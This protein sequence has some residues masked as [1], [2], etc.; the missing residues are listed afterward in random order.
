MQFHS[1]SSLACS[2][3][4]AATEAASLPAQQPYL[5]AASPPH[6]TNSP[7]Q[8]SF[9]FPSVFFVCRFLL[10]T[11][12]FWKCTCA[13][14]FVLFAP[15]MERFC[16]VFRMLSA[17]T[18]YYP[19]QEG[20]QQKTNLP[21]GNHAAPTHS[22]IHPSSCPFCPSFLVSFFCLSS[23]HQAYL[24]LLDHLHSHPH[25]FS[26][27]ALIEFFDHGQ[28]TQR[29]GTAARG[30]A[31]KAAEPAW[32]QGHGIKRQ[33]TAYKGRHEEEVKQRIAVSSGETARRC[34]PFCNKEKR[35]Q[36][37][38]AASADL[39]ARLQ[40]PQQVNRLC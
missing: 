4:T 11:F 19:N 38:Q 36:I 22:P 15:A 16:N 12:L 18:W 10:P 29:K 20:P 7:P 9:L 1:I 23:P 27:L 39:A 31:S 13:L 8:A 2:R 6:P 30:R 28:E 35:R 32:C 24:F 21:P 33:A 37:N 40:I 14:C 17:S 5:S 26:L 25:C 34:K 3:R